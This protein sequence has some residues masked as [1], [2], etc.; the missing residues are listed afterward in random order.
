[1]PKRISATTAAKKFSEVL[2]QVEHFNETFEVERHG[3]P[4]AQ[5]R[6]VEAAAPGRVLWGEALAALRAGPQPDPAFAEDLEEIRKSVSN[7][8]SD[9]WAHS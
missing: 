2:D 3:R 5:I 9:P 1:M 8:P 7:L 6:P 4:I